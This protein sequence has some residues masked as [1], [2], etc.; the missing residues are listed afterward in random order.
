MRRP[1]KQ[2]GASLDSL[3]DTMTNVVGILVILLIVTQVGV[4]SAVKRISTTVTVTPEEID[5]A[6][7]RFHEL[8]RLYEALSGEDDED[9]AD[10][11]S[12]L[13]RL[14]KAIEDEQAN[15]DVLRGQKEK[16]KLDAE[17]E[18]E[19]LRRQ[20]QELLDKQKEEADQLLANRD[21]IAEELASL[22]AQLAETPE[23]EGLPAKVITLPNPR[24]A[25][26]GTGPQTVLCREGRVLFVDAENIQKEAQK[27]VGF[28]IQRKKLGRDPAAGIDSKILAEEFNRDPPKN[29]NWPFDVKMTIAGR[30]AKL[31]LE[32]RE[33]GGETADEIK[34]S[35]S[36]YQRQ[37][38]RT[39][40]NQYYLRFL[41]WPD[42]FEAYL[43]ARKLSS[44]RDLLAGW[45]AQ[46]ATA[47][48]TIDLGGDLR[49]GPPPPPPKP[50]PKPKPG[51]APPPPP[52]PAAPPRPLPTDVI[53]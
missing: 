21:K 43:E 38:S 47:E 3:L 50:K 1:K 4:S 10:S 34:R 6:L 18:L 15:I 16:R 33:G 29:R 8:K 28:I 48:H 12:K 22:R 37:L 45:K 31:V 35:S 46:T 40:R 19:A 11:S 53:D 7:R 44:E 13:L 30:A 51:E 39:D 5:E 36:R 20:M 52:K 2:T 26:E 23:M 24:S 42:S 25:P 27:K 14:K 49:V 32:R 17:L 9:V 41:V